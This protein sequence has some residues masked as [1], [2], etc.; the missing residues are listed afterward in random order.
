MQINGA[1]I[2]FRLSFISLSLLSNW[3]RV[4]IP[5]ETEGYGVELVRLSVRLSVSLSV[6]LSVRPPSTWGS[7]CTRVGYEGPELEPSNFIHV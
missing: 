3:L 1:R 2:E 5:R 4:I 6:R 7:L